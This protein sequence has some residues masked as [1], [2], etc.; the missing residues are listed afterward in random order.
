MCEII[1][2]LAS[3]LIGSII[4]GLIAIY[5][6]ILTVRRT[7]YYRLATL[8]KT[9]FRGNIL[10]LNKITGHPVQFIEDIKTDALVEDIKSVIPWS[11]GKRF[12][13]YWN[14]YRY[15]KQNGEPWFPSEYTQLGTVEAKKL[16]RSRL[17]NLINSLK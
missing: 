2:A 9:I 15:D 16:I 10:E 13:A 3:G 7:E 5:A 12:V 14:E 17:I 11:K 8:L 4:G 6:G 1:I